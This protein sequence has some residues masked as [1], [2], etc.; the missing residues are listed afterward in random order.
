M[1]ATA[2]GSRVLVAIV[3]PTGAG[4]SELALALAENL[5]G[6]VVSFDAL[7]VYRGLDIGTAKMPLS[8]RRGIPHHLL[9]EVEADEDFSAAEFV[10]RAVPAIEGIAG[11]GKLPV[12][13]G[14]TGLY[15]RALRRGLFEGPGRSPGIRGRLGAIADRRGAR[16]LHRILRRWDPDLAGRI[17]PNDRV[18]LIRGIEVYLASGRRMSELMSTRRRPLPGFRDILIGLRPDREELRTRVEAR[19]HAMFSRGFVEEVR[20]LFLAHGAGIPAF[21]AIGYRDVLRHLDGE[22]DVEGARRQMLLATT[23]YAKRQM[24]W[25]R[26]EP[27]VQW[28]EGCG[29]DAGVRERVLDFIRRAIPDTG[30]RRSSERSHAETTP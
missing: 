1:R 12:L 24:T 30:A 29:D 27:E 7:Q 18:R 2:Q 14:G 19:V 3:G 26:R 21:K 11:Q 17:H 9:D 4:K 10:S 6:E 22:I 8:E 16:A 25:F 15:L 20:R 28:F 13:V 23:Q 5:G